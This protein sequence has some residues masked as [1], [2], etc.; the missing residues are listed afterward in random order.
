MNGR[1]APGEERPPSAWGGRRPP[2]AWGGRRAT[3]WDLLGSRLGDPATEW[4][5]A[6]DSP[7]EDRPPSGEQAREDTTAATI[8]HADLI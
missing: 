5:A 4:V 7:G 8:P 6:G 2:G 1:L 3:A